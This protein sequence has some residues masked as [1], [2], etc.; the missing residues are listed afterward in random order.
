M[1]SATIGNRESRR[2]LSQLKLEEV[3]KVAN[4][5]SRLKD[6][7]KARKEL[8]KRANNKRANNK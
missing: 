5:A 2:I 4:T 7:Q 1:A 3:Q 8:D 6:R